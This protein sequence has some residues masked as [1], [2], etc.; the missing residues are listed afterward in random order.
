VTRV[1]STVG[2]KYWLTRLKTKIAH[3]GR[4]SFGYDGSR[5][6]YLLSHRYRD[7]PSRRLHAGTHEIMKVL[8]ARSL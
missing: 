1:I 2:A 4:Q 8:I 6:E 3:G 5:S 7:K